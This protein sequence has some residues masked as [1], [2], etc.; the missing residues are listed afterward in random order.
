VTGPPRPLGRSSLIGAAG[1]TRSAG[2]AFRPRNSPGSGQKFVLCVVAFRNLLESLTA[3]L[4]LPCFAWVP[5]EAVVAYVLVAKYAWHLPL[6]WQAQMLLAQCLDIKRAIL[7][8]WVGYAAAELKP[9]YL[10]LARAQVVPEAA[11]F[12]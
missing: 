8:F 2:R 10:R 5:T 3:A 12:P 1:E 4:N 6:Y 11:W 7:A 9:L